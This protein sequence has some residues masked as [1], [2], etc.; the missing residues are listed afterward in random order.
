MDFVTDAVFAAK[1]KKPW[2]IKAGRKLLKR[3]D[4][5]IERNSLVPTTEFFDPAIFPWVAGFEAQWPKIR[6]ELDQVMLGHQ[7]LPNLQDISEDQKHITQDTLWK[8]FYLYG[9][10]YRSDENCARCPETTRL[11]EAIPGMRTAFF[12]ILAPGKHINA[13]RGPYKGVIRYHLGL[14]VPEPRDQCRIRVGESFACWQEGKSVLFDDTHSH[15]V[16]NETD[17]IRVV[18]FM[19]I[20]RPMRLPGRIL[21]RIA[22]T[23]IRL[24]PLVQRAQRNVKKSQAAMLKTA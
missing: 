21:N 12:S 22:F 23:L 9:Y 4:A 20:D 24:S 14:M 3:V 8:I 6:A 16:W 17:G 2:Y 18:L 7:Q 19:D 5:V 13:H 10:G 1:R 15:E 11:I